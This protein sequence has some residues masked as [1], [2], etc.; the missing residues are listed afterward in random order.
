MSLVVGSLTGEN[1]TGQLCARA[2]GRLCKVMQ[3]DIRNAC[4]WKGLRQFTIKIP[5]SLP[6]SLA[7]L[8]Y[9]YPDMQAYFQV[10]ECTR[11]TVWP[12]WPKKIPT[13]LWAIDT[14]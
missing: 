14:H 4:Q 6:T 7:G 3:F 9:R 10:D 11:R 8:I 12:M 2:L 5:K 13:A 1:N